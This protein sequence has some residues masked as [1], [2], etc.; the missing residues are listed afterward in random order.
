M[1]QIASRG[2]LRMSFLRSALVTVPAVLLLG[3]LSAVL[4]DSGYGNSWFAAL[5]K[6]D[7]MPPAWA[8]PVAWTILYVCLGFALAMILHARGARRR[9][10]ALGVFLLQLALNYAW[11]PIFF[12]FHL[13]WPAFAIICAII[14]LTLVA[15]MLFLRIR[16]GAAL[17]LLPYLAWLCFAAALNYR[18]ARLNPGGGRVA[19]APSSAD[20]PL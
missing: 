10:A 6:P 19:P 20:I 7:F 5:A 2:Q 16:K 4:A 9:R 12:G 15:A 18:I 17:L 11:S 13:V 3:T 14:A 1:T 8:F